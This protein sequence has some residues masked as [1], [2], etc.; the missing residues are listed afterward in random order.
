MLSTLAVDNY[1]SLYSIVVPLQRLTVITGANGVGKS[2]LYGALRLLV[3]AARGDVVS[4]LAREGGLP[5]VMW[6]GPANVSRAMERAEVPIQGGPR[7]GPARVKLGFSSNEFGYMIE[8]GLPVPTASAF[9]LDPVIKRECIFH[10]NAWRS[11]SALVD[12]KG[13]LLGRR[14]AR[15]WEVVATDLPVHD[16]LF[17]YAGDS[18]TVPEVFRLRETL[19]QWRF[20]ADFRTDAS[21]PARSTM[22]AT[23]TPVLHHDGR[24]LAAAI[25]TILEIGNAKSLADSIDDAF[26]GSTLEITANDV[27]HLMASLRQPGLLRSLRCAEWS[28]GTLRYI[29]LVA[30]LL[31]PRPPPLMVL[32]EPETSL[33]PDL[34]P[35]LARLIIVAS[36]NSQVWVI[37]HSTELVKRLEYV[38]DASNHVLEKSIGR[39]IVSGLRDLD[40]PAWRWS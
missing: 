17:D 3:A 8:L 35:P 20:Y 19:R 23:R 5:N 1:R 29:L 11:A 4:A 9:N 26:P 15:K 6:A 24:D 21:A 12:R 13:P 36:Q 37:S 38:D 31:T 22:T 34:I 7:Q 18:T 27:G 10:G 2:N 28:D 25:Q 16:S 40:A 39:T 30:A 14:S 32:N 33:H